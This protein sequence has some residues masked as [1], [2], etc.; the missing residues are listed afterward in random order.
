MQ[1]YGEGLTITDRENAI[2]CIKNHNAILCRRNGHVRPTPK[3]QGLL[4][5][6]TNISLVFWCWSEGSI[7]GITMILSVEGIAMQSSVERMTMSDQDQR[8]KGNISLS[9]TYKANP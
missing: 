6:Q 3:D 8:T 5:I 9:K 4:Y 1:L 7:E 2:P